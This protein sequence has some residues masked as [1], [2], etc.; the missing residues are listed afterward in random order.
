MTELVLAASE[1]A[2]SKSAV[3]ERARAAASPSESGHEAGPVP[4]LSDAARRMRRHRERR[5]LGLSCIA[6]A[7][8]RQRNDP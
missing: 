8:C 2:P 3:A 4:S 5:R 6:T 1:G 7:N